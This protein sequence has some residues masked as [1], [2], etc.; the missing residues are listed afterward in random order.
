MMSPRFRL[1]R[2]FRCRRN[3]HRI[4]VF[5]DEGNVYALTYSCDCGRAWATKKAV[6]SVLESLWGDAA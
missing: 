1:L 6:R 5:P 2:R 3:G 4:N